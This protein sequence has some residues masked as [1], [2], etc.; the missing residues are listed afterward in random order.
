MSEKTDML[1]PYPK[2]FPVITTDQDA[3]D[4][5]DQHLSTFD[6]SQFKPMRF[7]APPKSAQTPKRRQTP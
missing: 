5:L 7:E 1:Q 6:F 2:T 3:E 4:F